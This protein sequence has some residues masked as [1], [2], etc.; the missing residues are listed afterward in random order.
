M[1]NP[2]TTPTLIETLASYVPALI[3]RRSLAQSTA[4]SEPVRES[5]AAS[6]LFADISGFTALTEKLAQQGPVGVEELTRILNAYFGRLIALIHAHGGDI[7]KFAGDALLALWPV[8]A[9][10]DLASVT[11]QVAQCSLAIQ[12]ELSQYEV[13]E[14]LRLAL[15]MGIGCGEV[16]TVHV[17]G[18]F[19]RW[20]FL[21]AGAPLVQ[22]SMA[23]HQAQPGEIILAPEA[24]ELVEASCRGQ[25]LPTG[26][27]RL[28]AIEKIFPLH[29]L[30]KP[31]L[32]GAAEVALRGYIPAAILARLSAGQ[33]GWLAELRWVTVIFINLPD[34]NYA[35]PIE[36]AQTVMQALQT[37]LYRYEGSINKLSVDDKGI[38]LVAALG[39][40]PLAHEDDA[41]RGVQAALAM[42]AKL[43]E[44]GERAAIGITTGRVFCGSVGSEQRREYTLVGHVVNLAARLMQAAPDDILC[45]ETTYQIAHNRLTFEQLPAIKVKGKVDPVPVYRPSGQTK[46]VVRPQTKMVGRTIERK[47]L[48]EK[49]QALLQDAAGGIVVIEGEAGIGKSRLVDDL[50]KQAKA[51]KLKTLVG[52]GDAV[53]KSTPY[54]AWRSVF[55]QLFNLEAIAS[56]TLPD[57][58]LRRSNVLAQ[59]QSTPDG[60]R[61][62][63]L[64]NLVLPLDFPENE[65]TQQMSGKL[66]S[67]NIREL[68]LQILRGVTSEAPLLLILEDAHWLDS[69]S[70]AL[71]LAVTGR[72][73]SVLLVIATRPLTDPLPLEYRQILQGSE[74][75]HLPLDPLPAK[76]TVKLIC[77]RLGVKSLPE[78]VISLIHKKAEGHPFFSE[79][80]AFALRDAGL[81]ILANGECHIAAEVGDLDT[82]D[83]PDTIQGVITSRI[84]R[85]IPAQQLTLKVAS[86]IGRVF[87]F[88]ALQNIHPIE[89]D[90]A[91]L[92]DYLNTLQQL[93]ITPLETPEPELSYI[94]KHIIT[95]EVAYN[96][97]L[98]SQRRQLHRAVAEWYERT[99]VEDLTPF[100][101][102]LAHHWGKAEVFP[103]AIAYLEKA[104]EQAL[105]SYANREAVLFFTE[106]LRLDAQLQLPGL[107]T[108][109]ERRWQQARW[110]RQLG[111]A[112]LGLGQLLESRQHLEQ[113][114]ALLGCPVPTQRIN[115]LGILLGQ[116]GQQ[117]LHRL[118][119]QSFLKDSP[120]ARPQL[121]EAARG[122]ERITELNYYASQKIPT[123]CASICTLNLAERA[124]LSSELARAYA[125]MCTVV[126]LIPL[127]SL[128][129]AYA[130][131]A[132]AAVESLDHL[133]T[134]AFVLSRTSV[135]AIGVGQWQKI[136]EAI[137][138]VIQIS[139]RLEDRRQWG[140]A[141]VILAGVD[142]Y[143]GRFVNSIERYTELYTVAQRKNDVQFQA[144]ALSGRSQALLRLGRLD[145]AIADL[146]ATFPLLLQSADR[147]REIVTYGVL[148][149]VRLRQ[150][151]LDLAQQAA[152][153]ATTLIADSS[154]TS[155]YLLEGYAGTTEVYLTL[156]EASLNLL[157]Q[158]SQPWEKLAQQSL[159]SLHQYARIF[160]VNQPRYYLWQGLYF[161][162]KGQQA[163][164]YLIWQK[165]LAVAERLEMP[166]EA[167]LTHYQIG[168]HTTG[169]QQQKSIVRACE[170][171][172]NLGA[173]DDLTRA[174]A[175][176]QRQSVE[177][178]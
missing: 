12:Q 46:S 59:L 64:L 169:I 139:E 113:S 6:V 38:T 104:G 74:T 71:T 61:F 11:Q 7:V 36:Q 42:Q 148:G 112:Y 166:Y 137:A 176:M 170:I 133:S 143:Q 10:S 62:A 40:P 1:S 135:Y 82:L 161:W 138:Q 67:D 132:L 50:Q 91:Q 131:K 155:R 86:V 78:P 68:L 147:T 129:E 39:L 115:I 80:L 31:D 159:A 17:G 96:L 162:L 109:P 54:Y 18:V 128:A 173:V 53:E 122:Y 48:T 153:A 120:A 63:P 72:L 43:L 66:R 178:K 15:R 117:M 157:D 177:S 58:E 52:A 84:D 152:E 154:P 41:V 114:V 167:G 98:F 22:V 116:V 105:H 101:P 24:W 45:D 164:A 47:I 73:S 119:P 158:A 108:T 94:F 5:F 23:E 25:V 77:Q 57:L 85:L 70:W 149:M 21:V 4:V 103:N 51:L 156:W 79:E 75:Q 126:S 151:E 110:Q 88:R 35:T 100:Y 65:L 49:I 16:F 29:P 150:G 160:P 3:I 144:W 90:K 26:G 9:D 69:A 13:A 37:A 145:E 124:G 172:Q 20:E 171:F 142:Y 165:S 106:A 121:L 99:Y 92:V 56:E 19:K 146:D 168:R 163:Q 93:D 27:I 125:N 102:L 174:Q 136:R 141:L 81:I 107:T 175:I 89:V 60:L 55:S 95:Q 123:L 87:S 118:L 140:E 2:A 83:F 44:L 28:E 30:Q 14:G 134:Q 76:D 111:E 97:M 8:T 34:L 33:S 127:V 32:S 130:R